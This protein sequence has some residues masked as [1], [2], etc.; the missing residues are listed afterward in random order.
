MSEPWD[1]QARAALD[2]ARQ[3]LQDAGVEA[4]N[5][6]T[7]TARVEAARTEV[8][9]LAQQAELLCQQIEACAHR[10]RAVDQRHVDA[11]R[12]LFPGGELPDDT[13]YVFWMTTG[14][15]KVYDQFEHVLDRLHNTLRLG[16]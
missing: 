1:E 13:A 14:Y 2:N 4:M 7:L 8:T 3:R 10:L 6:D 12:P 15:D 5:T 11:I 9:I 16:P